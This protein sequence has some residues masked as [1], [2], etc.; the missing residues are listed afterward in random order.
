MRYRPYKPEDFSDLYRVEE[1]CFQPPFR[2]SRSYM[3]QI[4]SSPNS[5][6]WIVEENGSLA[7]FAVVDWT[8]ESTSRSAYIQTIEVLPIFR[9]MGAARELMRLTEESAV[10]AGANTIWLHVDV[11]NVAAI[12]LYESGGYILQDREEKYYPRG[13]DALIYRKLLERIGA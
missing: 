6:T 1:A 8:V 10:K 13:R 11:E 12:H 9:R 3:R 7:G 4:V 5:A 2:F